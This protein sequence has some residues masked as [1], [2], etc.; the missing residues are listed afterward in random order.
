M[1][2][3]KKFLL[4]SSSIKDLGSKSVVAKRKY[5][6]KDKTVIGAMMTI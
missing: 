5:N 6:V 1:M 4:N 3:V 2:R